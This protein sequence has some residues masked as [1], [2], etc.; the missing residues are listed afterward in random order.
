M[1]RSLDDDKEDVDDDEVVSA[2]F[3]L[4]L[5]LLLFYTI[6]SV[7]ELQ[8]LVKLPISHNADFAD[9]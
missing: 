8:L 1:T 5:F 3:A 9:S 2:G 7:I 4:L 6:L